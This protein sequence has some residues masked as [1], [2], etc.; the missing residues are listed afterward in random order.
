MDSVIDMLRAAASDDNIPSEISD[1]DNGE[2]KSEGPA[3]HKF[4]E[5]QKQLKAAL[6]VIDGQREKLASGTRNDQE[7]EDTR[8]ASPTPPQGERSQQDEAIYNALSVQ[9]CQNLG[10][11]SRRDAPRTFDLELARLWSNQASNIERSR[12]AKESAPAYID[13]ELTKYGQ[14]E[15]QDR[16]AVKQRL[17]K[18]DVLQ[19]VDPNVVRR[20]VASYLGEKALSADF[21][22]GGSE[23]GASGE[24]VSGDARPVGGMKNRGSS[25]VRPGSGAPRGG[26]EPK[27]ATPEERKDMKKLGI[28]DLEAYRAAKSKKDNY[29]GR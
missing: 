28:Q 18:L 8:A 22:A 26:N 7:R 16:G 5:Q 4:A 25:G 14:L 3:A 9:A 1:L 24:A 21:S 15:E 11:S 17:Q 27:P 23:Q 12:E 29:K 2:A 6:K 19:Q 13:N 20:E 10:I